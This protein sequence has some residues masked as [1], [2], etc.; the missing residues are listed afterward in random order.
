V[1]SANR[2][3]STPALRPVPQFSWVTNQRSC[4]RPPCTI[5]ARSRLPAGQTHYAHGFVNGYGMLGFQPVSGVQCLVRPRLALLQSV[6]QHRAVSIA[7]RG[8]KQTFTRK[9][10]YM[11][12]AEG[13]SSLAM[14]YGKC[15]IDT[16]AHVPY[17][18][19]KMEDVSTPWCSHFEREVFCGR[20]SRERQLFAARI[21][22]MGSAA[23]AAAGMLSADAAA[24]EQKPYPTKDD[25][26]GQRA[27]PRQ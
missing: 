17:C 14:A 15:S 10:F 22:G 5:P 21:S 19:A 11:R 2:C 1:G 12:T 20:Q 9:L 7:R 8:F 27:R 18:L 23:L 25:R 6:F 26:S 3:A 13:H 4:G 16:A 24:Q